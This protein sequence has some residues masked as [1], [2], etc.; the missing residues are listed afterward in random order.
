MQYARFLQRVAVSAAAICLA[1]PAFA[2]IKS[3]NKSFND[4]M[5]AKDYRKA[6]A[7]AA[8]T[9]AT[10]AKGR[11]DLPIIANEFGFAAFMATDYAAARTYATAA[12]AGN[13]ED[14]FHIGAELLLRLSQFK[15]T[16]NG[17]TRNGLQTAL[18]ASATLAGVDLVTFLGV[19]ALTSYD[20]DND[21]W[22]AAKVS[23]ALG[24]NLT[25][26][27]KAKPSAENL[28]F[29]LIRALAT[30]VSDRNMA[31]YLGLVALNEKVAAAIDDAA[32]DEEAAK[33]EPAF[34]QVRAWQASAAEQLQSD[35]DFRQG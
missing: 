18:E 30:Y 15:L 17:D 14:A 29:G 11:T 26:R 20:V 3:F 6:A 2:D 33:L 21:N 24:E 10:L 13:G 5:Q 34:W 19:N 28:T 31:S 23:A 25:G 16:P 8:S 7:E 35:G 9:W 32:S 4:A 27:G 12:L 22:R 1:L